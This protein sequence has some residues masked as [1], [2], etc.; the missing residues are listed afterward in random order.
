MEGKKLIGKKKTLTA[1]PPEST[2][3]NMQILYALSQ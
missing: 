1:H 2:F 3:L